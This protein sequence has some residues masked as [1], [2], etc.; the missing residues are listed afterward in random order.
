MPDKVFLDTNILLYA[1]S[2]KDINKHNIAKNIVLSQAVISTQVI[3][4]VAVNLIKKF[5]FSEDNIQK[6]LSSSYSRYYV[7]GLDYDVFS[8]ASDLR[9]KYMFSYY[10][11]LIVSA[12]LASHC[13]ILYSEDMHHDLLIENKLRIINPFK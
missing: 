2:T 8:A 6:F 3:N 4:E 7:V 9:K 10:D 11:S 1:F 5:D 13:T 12:A